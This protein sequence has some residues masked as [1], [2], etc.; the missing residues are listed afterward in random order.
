MK[1][2]LTRNV[3]LG[4]DKMGQVGDEVEF[5]TLPAGLSGKVEMVKEE[6]KEEVKKKPVA[7]KKTT[8]K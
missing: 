7:K 2:R 1:Y 6:V 5:E 4:V 8:A 3:V